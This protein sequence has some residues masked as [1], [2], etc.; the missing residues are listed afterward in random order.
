MYR[1]DGLGSLRRGLGIATRVV[2]ARLREY[3]PAA[4]AFARSGPDR[5]APGSFEMLPEFGANPGRL[6]LR[7][8]LPAAPLRHGAPLIVLLHGCG[9]DAATFAVDAGWT[10]LADRQGLPLLLPEQQ[11]ANN[12]QRCFQWF[13]PEETW[14]GHGEVSSVAAMVSAAVGRFGSDRGRLFV[15][16]LSAGGAM[17]AA[18]LVAYPDLFAA[19]AAFAGLPVGTTGSM[20]QA[21]ARMAHGGPHLSR[22][23]WVEHARPL[24]P[25]G[26]SGPWPRLSIWHGDADQI[27]VPENGRNLATQWR[28]LHGLPDTPTLETPHHRAWGNAVELWTLPSLGHAWAIGPGGG[29]PSQFSVPGPIDAVTEISRFWGIG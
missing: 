20:V 28:A 13:E 16:G 12:Q 18:L 25:P 1:S 5:W 19:G 11:E 27:V 23:E 3:G 14:R 17:A 4:P 26:C 21:L 8:Y 10:G 6:R 2:A 22:E 9:Q 29:R 7:I 15:A 24:A